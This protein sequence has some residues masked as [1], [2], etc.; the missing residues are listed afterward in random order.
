MKIP[1]EIIEI[2]E[3][4][5]A[6]KHEAWLVGGCVRD[7]L[8][9]RKIDDW[10]LA[11][12]AKPEEITAVFPDSK[13]ENEFGTVL[14]KLPE[15][16]RKAAG[17]KAVEITTFRREAKYTD[18][19]HPDKV[20]FTDKLED[21]LARRDFTV[22]A[23]AL[24]VKSEELKVKSKSREPESCYEIIDLFGGRDDLDKKIIRAV[25][26]PEKRF[27]EDAL[28]MIRAVRFAAQLGFE[29]EEKTQAAIK[30]NAKWLE[31]ISQERLRTELEKIISSDNAERGIRDLQEAGLLKFVIPELEE[32]VGVT[33]NRHHIYTVFEHNVRSLGF[34]AQKK[35]S[36]V[37]RLAALLHDIG[38][39]Q[40]KQGEGIEATFYNH[41]QAGARQARQ[42]LERLRFPKE[43]VG[44]VSHLIRY[45]M[46]VYDV[47]TVSEAGVRRLVRR[48]K[49]E[50]LDESF[51]LRVADRLGSGVP[52]A[53]PYKLRHLRYMMERVAK[54]PIS[55]K[56]LKVNGHDIMST[57]GVAPGP[58]VGAILDV[59]LAEVIE[60]P[61]RNTKKYLAPRVRELDKENLEKLR[62]MAKEVIE[63]KREKEDE[64]IKRKYWVK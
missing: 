43:I 21:D 40:T 14:V 18:K 55:V 37:V 61:K 57:L 27:G 34:A 54:D 48:I 64:E 16:K 63:E 50:N 42:I 31:K 52:K 35:F 38:K 11:T 32:G 20:E 53:V 23:M 59:L 22:N 12:S 13:Y 4:L 26:E 10:D 28:R 17:I 29:I 1:K 3:K 2:L 25:G 8:L 9:E 47:G 49:P 41:E 44:K 19:R 33:Q 51:D 46:F 39:V 58:K 30:K 56:M 45:H 6:A 36:F 5:E 60:D 24:Q 62:E 15:E 7:L